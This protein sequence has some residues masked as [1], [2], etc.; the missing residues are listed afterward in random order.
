M[1]RP[2]RQLLSRAL[3]VALAWGIVYLT[4][5]G[6][7]KDQVAALLLQVGPAL[8][9]ILLPY[10][11]AMLLEG[12]LFQQCFG[13]LGTQ[14]RVI[15]LLGVILVGE[16]LQSVL[17]GGVVFS[18]GCKPP[19]LAAWCQIR[20]PVALAGMAARKYVRL[21]AHVLYALTSFGLGYSFL[22]SVSHAVIG[23]EGL[24]WLVLGMAFLLAGVTTSSWLVFR[25][26]ALAARL[27]ALLTRLPWKRMQKAV[28]SRSAEF[29]ETDLRAAEFFALGPRE[30][31]I[32]TATAY[33]AWLA[34]SVETW[35]ILHFLGTNL[36]F[37][38][39]IGFEVGLLLVRQLILIV[40]SGLGVQEL[41][42]VAFLSA[43]QI[44]HAVETGAAFALLKRGKEACWIALGFLILLFG[45]KTKRG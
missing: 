9:L 35:L 45:K 42:Y 12:L 8:L 16:A 17:P 44:P 27:H 5:R 32:P 23:T 29:D 37:S 20:G 19:L 34:E 38:T 2:S 33:L 36:P 7:D 1:K 25:R 21:I 43:L 41:G 18:E 28:Q 4:F 22:K 6:V 15:P 26:G 39:V 3:G 31:A 10:A 11:A 40:P 30:L 14:A 24:E 13:R